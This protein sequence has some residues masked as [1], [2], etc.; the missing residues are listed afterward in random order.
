MCDVMEKV[1]VER[2]R[3]F[4]DALK[5]NGWGKIRD[6]IDSHETLRT[7]RDKSEELMH[8][9]LQSTAG[10]EDA[11]E[12]LRRVLRATAEVNAET[13][14]LRKRLSTAVTALK[15]AKETFRW[16]NEVTNW[17]EVS[18]S[19]TKG[20]WEISGKEMERII[21]ALAAVED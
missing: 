16:I 15:K 4:A 7:E 6:L 20:V 1:E 12:N 17:K 11:L 14:A 10:G 8:H 2:L 21:A 18:P 3:Q 9:V 5:A 13:E 19:M